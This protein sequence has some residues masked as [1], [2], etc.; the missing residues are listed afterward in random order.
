MK[1]RYL[2]ALLALFTVIALYIGRN[3]PD[4]VVSKDD[5]DSEETE[6][7]RLETEKKSEEIIKKQLLESQVLKDKAAMPAKSQDQVEEVQKSF[8]EHMH[9]MGVCLGMNT[10]VNSDK[11]DPTFD[12]MMASLRPAIGDIVVKMDDWTQADLRADDG[13]I[14]RLRTEMEYNDSS[15]PTRR[16]QLYKINDQGLPEMQNLPVDQALN[17]TDEYL[18][19]LRGSGKALIDEKGSRVYYSE[20]EELVLVERGGKVQSFSLTKG[21]KTF[22]CTDT[23]A[24]TSNCQCL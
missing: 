12:S 6:V 24:A 23:D 5:D 1:F 8:S 2:F 15:T 4:V 10:P 16:V 22:S 7:T 13:S 11:V 14:R 3:K 21:E 18:E 17:P 9:Q 19:S 20:G